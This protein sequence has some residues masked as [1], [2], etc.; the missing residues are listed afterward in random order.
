MTKAETIQMN[1][2][3]DE[4]QVEKKSNSEN[5]K[6][7]LESEYAEYD[8]ND[9]VIE[10]FKTIKTDLIK[11]VKEQDILLKI[12]KKNCD[13]EMKKLNGRKKKKVSDGQPKKSGFTKPTK[14]PGRVAEFLGVTVDTVM[15]RTDVTK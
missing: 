11:L 15:P 4:V 9:K 13:V 2:T 12:Y 14:I 1:T 3:T 5:K 8:N 6:L 10:R 7:A